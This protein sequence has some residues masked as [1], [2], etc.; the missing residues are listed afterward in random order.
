MSD[1]TQLSHRHNNSSGN[2]APQLT[3][4]DNGV[5]PEWFHGGITRKSAEELLT[6]KLPGCFLVRVS[7]SRVGYT[8]SYRAQKRCRHFM[9]EAKGDS[10]AIVGEH[11]SHPGLQ[12]LVD[13]HRKVPIA[14]YTEVLM[15]SCGQTSNGGNIEKN[16]ENCKQIPQAAEEVIPPQDEVRSQTL[17][18]KPVPKSRKRY[19]TDK[20]PPPETTHTPAPPCQKLPA[21]KRSSETTTESEEMTW[22][23]LFDAV[24]LPYMEESERLPQEYNPPPPF[25]PNYLKAGP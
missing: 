15:T 19:T 3:W 12:Q 10:F 17:P 6:S 21:G 18:V 4:M 23:Q 9:I 14:P 11:R 5:V 1:L 22:E 8:L 24:L 25:A 20:K 7:E 16:L 2:T 13:F